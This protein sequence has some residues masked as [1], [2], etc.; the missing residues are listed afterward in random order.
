MDGY[1]DDGNSRRESYY[2]YNSPGGSRKS[3]VPTLSISRYSLN[4]DGGF[5]NISGKRS[6]SQQFQGKPR[7]SRVPHLRNLVFIT[8]FLKVFDEL[9]SKMPKFLVFDN[10]FLCL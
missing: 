3:S 6:P 2:S 9:I 4:T 10:F 1:G 5:D 7:V 8:D